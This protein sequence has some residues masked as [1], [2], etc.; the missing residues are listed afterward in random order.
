MA[1]EVQCDRCHEPMTEFGGLC[2]GPPDRFGMARKFH[3]CTRCARECW[4]WIEDGE[5]T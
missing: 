3:L 2:F 4:W 5:T 1:I